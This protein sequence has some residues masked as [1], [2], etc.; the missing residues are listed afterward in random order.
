[1]Y[2]CAHMRACDVCVSVCVMSLCAGVFVCSV[3]ICVCV[4]AGVC[5]KCS[6][7]PFAILMAIYTVYS[8]VVYFLSSFSL[9][10]LNC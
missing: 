1:M 8:C 5:D 3:I 6:A 10:I 7:W 9:S 2:V 4:R